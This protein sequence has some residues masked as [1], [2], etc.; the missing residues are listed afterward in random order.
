MHSHFVLLVVFSF[1]VSL[2]F[3]LLHGG[4]WSAGAG[5]GLIYGLVFV[6][7]GRI[8]D[9]ILAHAVTNALLAAMV[10]LGGAWQY[11]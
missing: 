6:R 8:A 1:F 3:A 2:V 4:R 7:K 5:A 11:W 9:C 10:T